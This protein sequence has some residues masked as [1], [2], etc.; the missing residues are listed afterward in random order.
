MGDLVACTGGAGGNI[1]LDIP[2]HSWPPEALFNHKRGLSG[3]R[4]TSNEISVCPVDDLQTEIR[5]HKKS[6]GWAAPRWGNVSIDSLDLSPNSPS[7]SSYSS[8]RGEDVG[9]DRGK[10]VM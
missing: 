4:M 7:D 9:G 3:A 8:G 6:I 2:L 10:R 5:R 1:V